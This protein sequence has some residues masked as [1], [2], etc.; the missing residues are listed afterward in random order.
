M[1]RIA[2]EVDVD[3]IQDNIL[4]VT[5]CN[6]EHELVRV[7]GALSVFIVSMQNICNLIG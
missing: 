4:S 7:V 3:A 5:Y 1:D 6:I 2:H